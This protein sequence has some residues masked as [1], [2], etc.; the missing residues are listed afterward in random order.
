MM[1]KKLSLSLS[2]PLSKKRQPAWWRFAGEGLNCKVVKKKA[3]VFPIKSKS[4]RG[5]SWR[6]SP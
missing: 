1:M 6:K 3:F 4:K 5:P 2:I